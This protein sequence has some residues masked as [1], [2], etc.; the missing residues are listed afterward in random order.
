MVD[1]A[2]GGDLTNE[3]FSITI[4]V[5]LQHLDGNLDTTRKSNGYNSIAYFVIRLATSLFAN[6]S[7]MGMMT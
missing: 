2:N 1:P 7:P 3:L 4:G 5:N 6:T